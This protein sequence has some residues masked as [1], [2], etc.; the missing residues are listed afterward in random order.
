MIRSL[1]IQNY[2]L[3]ESLNIEIDKGLTI[4]TGETGAGKS[5]IL[6]A[7]SLI[8]GQRADVSVIQNPEKKC[9][10]EAIFDISKY[11]LKPQFNKFDIDYFDTTIIRREISAEGRSR[12]F[13]NDTPV[14]LSMLKDIVNCLIDIHS[15]HDT[16]ELN[17]NIFQTETLDL[18][19]GNTEVLDN[20]QKIHHIML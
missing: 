2:A 8:M 11:D 7:L 4:I 5:I 18:F 12:A 10:V 15:Q 20:Y 3:I 1:K 19:V 13:V 16:L 14:N 6:G 9:V 17:N